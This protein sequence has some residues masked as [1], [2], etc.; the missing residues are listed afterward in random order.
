M[1]MNTTDL[2]ALIDST[3]SHILDEWTA[4]AASAGTD[5]DSYI[6]SKL[7]ELEATDEAASIAIGA[8]YLRRLV[9]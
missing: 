6:G 2:T 7:D 4:E 5:T 8:A 9:A 1:P 3:T